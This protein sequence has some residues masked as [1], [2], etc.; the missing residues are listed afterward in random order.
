MQQTSNFLCLK[1]EENTNWT[2]EEVEIWEEPL[3]ILKNVEFQVD[4]TA[5]S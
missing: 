5:F 4:E 1:K 2:L 3:L